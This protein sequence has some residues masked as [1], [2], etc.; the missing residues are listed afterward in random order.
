MDGSG[1]TCSVRSVGYPQARDKL[2]LEV[3]RMRNRSS[4]SR[5]PVSPSPWPNRAP[6]DT[7]RE[8]SPRVRSMLR[9][10][11]DGP[12]EPLYRVRTGHRRRRARSLPLVL[13][14]R[15]LVGIR[16]VEQRSLLPTARSEHHT[17]QGECETQHLPAFGADRTSG[18]GR[19]RGRR[20]FTHPPSID[21]HRA[22]G[23]RLDGGSAIPAKG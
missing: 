19:R 13:P 17:G 4:I 3:R 8:D 6:A 21:A 11:G 18:G 2:L 20:G 15:L 10:K 9:V 5:P 14:A 7:E 12:A 22:P 1:S 23:Q 16:R